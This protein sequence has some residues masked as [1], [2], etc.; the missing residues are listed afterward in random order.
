MGDKLLTSFI[1]IV[2]AIIGV[3]IVAIIFSKS[4]NTALV[5]TSAGNFFSK[6]LGAILG[7]VSSSGLG[8]IGV[9]LGGVTGTGFT[10]GS[11]TINL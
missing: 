11:T 7:P 3:A 6:V 5:F 4:S 1:G 10:G 9:N 2:T 8:T